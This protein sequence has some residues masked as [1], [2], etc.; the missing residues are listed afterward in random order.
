MD[1]DR[2]LRDFWSRVW[3]GKFVQDGKVTPP[4]TLAECDIFIDGAK[5]AELPPDG[6]WH[7]VEVLYAGSND[8]AAFPAK[9]S[10][11]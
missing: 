7:T 5:T 2:I 4:A 10:Q 11:K 9:L 3:A 1:E 6:R 8:Y